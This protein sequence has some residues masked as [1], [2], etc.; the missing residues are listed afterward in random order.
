MNER[1][2]IVRIGFNNIYLYSESDINYKGKNVL[3]EFFTGDE[4]IYEPIK[5]N[6]NFSYQD[7]ETKTNYTMGLIF[8]NQLLFS[9]KAI[10]RSEIDSFC[11]VFLPKKI[12]QFSI[13][14]VTIQEFYK[15][16]KSGLSCKELME[17]IYKNFIKSELD[18]QNKQL[19]LENKENERNK[20]KSKEFIY[21]ELFPTKAK[22]L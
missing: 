15:K 16:V 8:I 3:K 2:F 4:V 12:K 20:L 10:K 17:K 22:A 5:T 13:E 7:D 14:E 21:S 9:D 11:K 18:Y 1:F 6:E 19:K